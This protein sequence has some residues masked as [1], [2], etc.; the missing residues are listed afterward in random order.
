MQDS[1]RDTTDQRGSF[2][3]RCCV[4]VGAV[5]FRSVLKEN[6]SVETI[7]HLLLAGH[8]C[9]HACSPLGQGGCDKGVQLLHVGL[10]CWNVIFDFPCAGKN[11]I[12]FPESVSNK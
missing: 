4:G 8:V 11:T 5:M 9:Q 7:A 3:R 1:D 2:G 10:E 6:G 12:Y